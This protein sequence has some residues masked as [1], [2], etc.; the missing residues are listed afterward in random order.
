[1][2]IC[3]PFGVDSAC[4]REVDDEAGKERNK[5]IRNFNIK[6]AFKIAAVAASGFVMGDGIILGVDRIP[7]SFGWKLAIVLI[8]DG[9]GGSLTSL[10]VVNVM[11][12]SREEFLSKIDFLFN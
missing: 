7:V 1:M 6:T 9:V 5:Q 12:R 3:I 2:C 10:I 8:A 11:E 4:L